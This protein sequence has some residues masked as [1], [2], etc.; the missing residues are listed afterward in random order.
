MY[1]TG[2]ILA[3]K[4]LQWVSFCVVFCLVRISPR[5][6]PGMRTSLLSPSLRITRSG[7]GVGG[8][9]IDGARVAVGAGKGDLPDAGAGEGAGSGGRVVEGGVGMVGG[10]GAAVD[11]GTDAE[12]GGG[13]ITYSGVCA[14]LPVPVSDVHARGING[15]LVWSQVTSITRIYNYHRHGVQYVV[16]VQ[17]QFG[18]AFQQ[19]SLSQDTERVHGKTTDAGS[20]SD[21]INR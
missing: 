14:R 1:A 12:T 15:S 16:A 6:R 17:L 8:G 10:K 7:I 2:A 4:Y 21:F 19:S 3:I 13:V 11:G 20:E 18:V 5:V 9:D